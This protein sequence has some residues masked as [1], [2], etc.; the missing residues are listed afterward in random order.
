MT[1]F[2]S[3]NR[4]APGPGLSLLLRWLPVLLH[5][6][7]PFLMEARAC[8]GDI[9]RF[10]IGL[11]APMH[12]ISHPDYIKHVLI[13]SYRN[14]RKVR[15]Y[16]LLELGFGDGLFTSEGDLWQRQR[17]LIQPYF[18]HDHIAALSTLI[19]NA[20]QARLARWEESCKRGAVLEIET[21]MVEVVRKAMVHALFSADI[22]E[23]VEAVRRAFLQT[24]G[25]SLLASRLPTPPG[26]RRL[27][28]AWEKLGARVREII[29]ERKRS[30]HHTGDLL[31]MLMQARD[32]RTGLGMSDKQ[33]QDEAITLIF[34]GIETAA[35]ALTWTWY[36]LAQHPQVER[37]LHAELAEV[38]GGRLPGFYDLPQLRYTSMV[39]H[40]VLRLFPPAWAN[41]RCAVRSDQI[42]GYHIP[43]G[44]IVIFSQYVMHRH[45]DFWENPDSFDPDR[46]APERSAVRPDY[47]YFPF[48]GG[49]RQC[50]G[51]NFALME[52][53]LVLAAIA[54]HF[55]LRFVPGQPVEL[56]PTVTLQSRHGIRMTLE[57]IEHK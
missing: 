27:L 17:R 35:Q 48:G 45:P 28:L 20:V 52:T 40:E 22:G 32:K 31:S 26:R 55:R 44:S 19:T 18:N 41:A 43:A 3:P 29:R 38:L 46:F 5:N 15:L 16:S 39:I 36:L 51:R 50:I 1:T 53:Q 8:Y 56:N 54:Q 14:F 7:L 42:G 34:T 57:K 25:P 30:G 9:V 21:E 6:P 23:E 2:S 13:D 11:W 37:K 24:V 49:P 4:N 12:L 33:V 10:Q 47:V